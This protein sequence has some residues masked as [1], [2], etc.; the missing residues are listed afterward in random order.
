MQNESMILLHTYSNGL[1]EKT[2]IVSRAGED[3]EQLELSFVVGGMENGSTA[4]RNHLAVSDRISIHLPLSAMAVWD[5]YP[6]EIKTYF[7]YT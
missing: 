4:L 2:L 3:V 6:G 5:I 1:K 7:R